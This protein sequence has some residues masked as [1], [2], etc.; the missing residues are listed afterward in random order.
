[1]CVLALFLGNENNILGRFFYVLVV[2]ARSLDPKK[3][4]LDCIYEQ[5]LPEDCRVSKQDF[6]DDIARNQDKT[7]IIVD[8]FDEM[9][10]H[11]QQTH[12]DFSKLI[13]G[14]ILSHVTLLVTSRPGFALNMVRYFDSL[15]VIVGYGQQE[16]LQFI[17]K[18]SNA[19]EEEENLHTPTSSNEQVCYQYNNAMR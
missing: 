14:K 10:E 1:M 5:L 11:K 6:R 16:R 12:A 9:L 4:V 19:F 3:S 8:G 15:L 13:Q 17:D 18:F 2:Q 7:L